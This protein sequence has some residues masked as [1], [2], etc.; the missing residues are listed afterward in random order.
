MELTH[1]EDEGAGEP[2]F[3]G[4]KI[5]TGPGI[6]SRELEELGREPPW[7]PAALWPQVP[8]IQENLWN[9]TCGSWVPQ[10]PVGEDSGTDGDSSSLHSSPGF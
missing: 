10:G 9:L 8:R 1:P 6:E 4:P 7:S 3:G 2:V 5:S